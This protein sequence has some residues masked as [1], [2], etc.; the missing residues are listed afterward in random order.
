MKLIQKFLDF[1]VYSNLFI[2]GCA[3]VMVNQTFHLV[4]H[5]KADLNLALFVLFSTL[6][7]YSFH[8]WLPTH[9]TDVSP[10]SKWVDKF[11][12]VYIILF[13][14]GLA[15]SGIFFFRLIDYWP[16]LM[17]SAFVTFLYSAP[18]ISHPLFRA[19]RK[20][21][22]GKTIF[23]AFVWMFVTTVLPIVISGN[24]LKGDYVFFIFSRFF[25]IYAICILFDL[26]DKDADKEAG[27]RS[28]VT[29]LN[30]RGN[31]YLFVASLFVFVAATVSLLYY[32]YSIVSVL[33]LLLPGILAAG[34][35][36]FSRRQNADMFY[37]LVLDGLMALSAF[38]MLVPGI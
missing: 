6:C 28:L 24:A 33:I 9:V 14:I 21:A 18:K 4:L 2:A 22:L 5:E 17:V 23:L 8:W 7:S 16:W 11:R 38:I 27:I 34:F 15:G 19:L 36:R 32:H 31:L 25:L 1:L 13:I 35:Y 20:V 30:D 37:Y 10:R 29:Y 3:V 26:R 12:F